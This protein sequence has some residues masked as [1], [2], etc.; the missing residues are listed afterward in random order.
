MGDRSMAAMIDDGRGRGP[1]CAMH[2]RCAQHQPGAVCV[3]RRDVV[4][5]GGLLGCLLCHQT[6]TDKQQTKTKKQRERGKTRKTKTKPRGQMAEAAAKV[7]GPFF[8]VSGAD[9]SAS[10]AGLFFSIFDLFEKN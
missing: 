6:A 3:I 10:A 4:L 7:F 9:A 2:A 1:S 8:E 5:C